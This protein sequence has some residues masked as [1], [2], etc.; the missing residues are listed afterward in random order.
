MPPMKGLWESG[1]SPGLLRPPLGPSAQMSTHLGPVVG[2]RAP[3][4]PQVPMGWAGMQE[5]LRDK[6]DSCPGACGGGEGGHWRS[7]GDCGLECWA[8]GGHQHGAR[9]QLSPQPALHPGKLSQGTLRP[10]G[11]RHR[12]PL[13]EGGR[14]HQLPADAADYG[15]LVPANWSLLGWPEAGEGRGQR[16]GHR[17][18][19]RGLSGDPHAPVTHG[20]TC[21][22]E[23]EPTQP[24]LGG[25][26]EGLL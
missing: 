7:R 23:R 9:P 1:H 6:C 15:G 19:V 13:E 14:P 8:R 17:P 24:R 20:V 12:A 21:R 26:R 2:G 10:S 5:P 18:Q 22:E 4:G 11:C 3:Q 25:R 16:E